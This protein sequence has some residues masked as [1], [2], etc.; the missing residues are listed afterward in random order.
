MISLG[1]GASDSVSVLALAAH[2]DDIEIGAGG[3]ILELLEKRR[4]AELTWVVF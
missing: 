2:A 3:L 1:L 4:I